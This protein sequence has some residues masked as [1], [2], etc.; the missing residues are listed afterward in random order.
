MAPKVPGLF[1]NPTTGLGGIGAD[2]L[3]QAKDNLSNYKAP[4]I[5]MEKLS[6]LIEGIGGFQQKQQ[7]RAKGFD[8]S[9]LYQ[10]LSLI[11]I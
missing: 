4:Q 8:I 7:Q 9:E 11:H 3:Q 1:A 2:K 5:D 6:G 10:E